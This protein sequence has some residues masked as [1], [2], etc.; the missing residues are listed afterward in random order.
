M[1]VR[2]YARGVASGMAVPYATCDAL[3]R[4]STSSRIGPIASQS[5]TCIPALSV[6]SPAIQ[7]A[8]NFS[9]SSEPRI[10]SSSSGAWWPTYSRPRSYWSE[11]KYGSRV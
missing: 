6:P 1:P 10:S 9:S 7:N 8:W 2:P 5:L 4:V 3:A 11:K